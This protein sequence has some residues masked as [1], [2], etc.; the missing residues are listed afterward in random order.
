MNQRSNSGTSGWRSLLWVEADDPVNQLTADER[1]L[2]GTA[3]KVHLLCCLNCK[4]DLWGYP[5][6]CPFCLRPL[7][8]R[9]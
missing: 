9:G 1:D 7:P 4:S 5:E 2:F 8:P 6:R 3:K